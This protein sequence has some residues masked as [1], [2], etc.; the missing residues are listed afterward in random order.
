MMYMRPKIDLLQDWHLQL[1]DFIV[2][3][4]EASQLRLRNLL[5]DCST[6]IRLSLF[7]V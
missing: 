6:P 5:D 3:D 7:H 4:V 2:T 1:S